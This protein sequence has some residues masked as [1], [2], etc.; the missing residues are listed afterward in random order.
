MKLH[1]LEP[2]TPSP[3][4]WK[5]LLLSAS[6]SLTIFL[7][8]FTYLFSAR[9]SLCGCMS[10][11]LVAASGGFSLWWFLLLWL[12]KAMATDSS[13]LTWKI[14]QT[15]E[16]GGLQSMGS[17]RV[18]H[19]WATSLSLFTFHFHALEKEMATHSSILTWRIPGM[20]EPGGLPSMSHRVGQDWS[21]L[22]A[23]AAACC[24]ARALGQEG[25]SSCD[26][27]AQQLWLPGSRARAQKLWPTGLVALLHV[28]S[29]WIR[30]WTC[31]SWI[32]SWILYHWAT[33]EALNLTILDS[34]YKSDQL[35]F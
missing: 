15:E 33:R 9:Q 32:G 16:P 25:F 3:R 27:R 5:S 7:N 22:A 14:P 4:P 30:D 19:D 20:G 12:E 34:I 8:F 2:H 1:T 31:I 10:V 13:T 11:S 35:Y 18:R 28:R 24:R 26:M 6:M 23:A 17:L 29:S 21:V